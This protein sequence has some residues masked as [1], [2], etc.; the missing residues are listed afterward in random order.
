MARKPKRS[1]RA[2]K[3]SLMFVLSGNFQFETGLLSHLVYESLEEWCPKQNEMLYT[4][5]HRSGLLHNCRHAML[6]PI[7]SEDSKNNCVGQLWSGVGAR[8]G[9]GDNGRWKVIPFQPP[10]TSCIMLWA[11][12][13]WS[14]K[15]IRPLFQVSNNII[16][17]PQNLANNLIYVVVL[18]QILHLNYSP[19]LPDFDIYTSFKY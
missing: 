16:L 8:G 18:L 2:Y 15:I 5:K 9:E 1:Q 6:H 7:L 3:E 17:R 10:L 11:G 13:D 4:R 19:R 14:L 12:I